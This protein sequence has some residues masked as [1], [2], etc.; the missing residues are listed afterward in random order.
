MN[1]NLKT[2]IIA[3]VILL[4]ILVIFLFDYADKSLCKEAYYPI[5]CNNY[6]D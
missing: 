5:K 6:W 2:A 4:V 1:K 3:G